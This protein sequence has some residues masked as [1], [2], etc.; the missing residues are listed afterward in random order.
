MSG[1]HVAHSEAGPKSGGESFI[2]KLPLLGKMLKV[3]LSKQG[4]K[5]FL[6][7]MAELPVTLALGA[8]T[9]FGELAG[10]KGGGGHGH[11]GH[12]GHVTVH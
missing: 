6:N 11:G 10:V 4:L 2:E 1:G 8:Y 7:K 9:F 3:I 5:D 12:G